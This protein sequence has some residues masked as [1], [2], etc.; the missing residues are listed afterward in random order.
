MTENRALN[1]PYPASTASSESDG[2]FTSED[3]VARARSGRLRSS[4]MTDGTI[5]ISA[6]GDTGADAMAAVIY[7]PQVAIVGFGA[8]VRRPWITGD[9]I[10]PRVTVTVTLSADHR[11]SDGR[12]GAKFLAAV[13]AAL[14][15][16]EAL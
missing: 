4:E 11:V 5:T 7:P 6:M 10:A 9:T 12:S 14:Q 3:L 13:A 16:P 2:G 1:G 15:T 8:P